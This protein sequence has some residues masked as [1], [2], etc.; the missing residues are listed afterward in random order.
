MCKWTAGKFAYGPLFTHIVLLT[1]SIS[2]IGF[3]VGIDL[4]DSGIQRRHNIGAVGDV[5]QG[6]RGRQQPH[7][8]GYGKSHGILPCLESVSIRRARCLDA[9][10]ASVGWVALGRLQCG[11]LAGPPDAALR[12]SLQGSAATTRQDGRA[13]V[14]SR[15]AVP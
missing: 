11:L 10:Q 15:H 1:E 5:R 14:L 2:T 9:N 8:E 12:L 6:A 13:F 4:V 3:D 7:G